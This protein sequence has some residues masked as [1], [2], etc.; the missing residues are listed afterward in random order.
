MDVAEDRF[1]LMFERSADAIL[2]LDT[3]TNHFV[4]YNQAALDM[5]SCTREEL[6]ALHPSALSP[7]HQPDGTD[8][9]SAANERIATAIAQGS[10]RFEWVHRSPHRADFPVEVLL[11]PIQSGQAPLILVVWRDITERKRS[12]EAL[13][14][15]QKLESLGVLAGGV[16]HDFNNLLTA[17]TGRLALARGTLL[18]GHP[19]RVHLDHLERAAT[20]AAELCRQMLAYSGHGALAVEAVDVGRAV[21][22]LGELLRAGTAREVRLDLDVGHG[23]LYARANRAE[24]QQVILN[25][26]TN[27]AEASRP[28]DVV[29]VRARTLE[30]SQAEL[31]RDYPS[32]G[33]KPGSFVA[34]EVEDRGAGMSP[35]VRARIFDPF[36]STKGRGRGLGLSALLGIVRAHQG[37][38]QIRSAPGAG[39]HFT[40]LFPSAEPGPRLAAAKAPATPARGR[41]RVLVVDDHPSVRSSTAAILSTMGFEVT[42]AADGESALAAWQAEPGAFGW[43]LMDLTMPGMDG[44]QAWKAMRQQDPGAKVI[45]TSGWAASELAER[46]R[47]DPPLAFLPKPWRLEQLEDVLRRAGLLPG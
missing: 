24:L 34:L 19:A 37:G 15:A 31:E 3:S 6:R 16:A 30:M 8:S 14:Q 42:E 38:L 39:T 43:A 47:D 4:E 1:R 32:Q 21:R 20:T 45:F 29:S 40:V 27:A 2:L 46:F 5:L 7:S 17:I 9:F 41:G 26:V 22:E 33:M 36:F 25:L 10:N 44:H 23:A 13:R 12:E 11:T 18:E 28:G 35:E